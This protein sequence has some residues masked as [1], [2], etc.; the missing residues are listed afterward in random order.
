MQEPVDP[1]RDPSKSQR[2]RDMLALQKL[3]ETLVNLS[4]AELAKIP[5]DSTLADA[6]AEARKITSHEGRRRQL[7]F[8][9][10]VMRHIDLTETQAALDKLL[11][12]D[13]QSKVLFHQIERWRDRLI[14]EEDTTLHAFLEKFPNSD[15]QQLRQLV[16]KAKDE[17]KAEKNLGGEAKLFRFLREIMQG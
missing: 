5:L 15:R 13:Q 6:I 8:I 3:G 9:G 14:A 16:R 7:Q 2:K 1:K 12:K 17:H 10:K 11:F 4:N